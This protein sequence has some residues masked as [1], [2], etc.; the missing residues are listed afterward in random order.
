MC[1]FN[2]DA[3]S[4]PATNAADYAFTPAAPAIANGSSKSLNDKFL[5]LFAPSA[6]WSGL[7][8]WKY[9]HT[10]APG[11]LAGSKSTVI[12]QLG[13]SL[14]K[15]TAQCGI[16]Y[17]YDGE[18]TAAPAGT[19]SNLTGDGT[20]VVGWNAL[21]PGMSAWTY[22]WYV[23][24][25]AG[26]TLVESDVTL[27]PNYIA[28]LADL[29]RVVTHEWGHALGLAHS[30][31]ESAI[32]AGPPYTYY[33]MLA[34]P[35]P[36]DL[37]GCRCLYGM[38]PGM[39]ASYACSLPSQ[40]DFGSVAVGTQSAMQ[41]VTL[42]NSGN[43]PMSV[44]GAAVTTADFRLVSGCGSGTI[45]APGG[46]CT[47]QLAANPGATGPVKAS[48]MLA[49]NDGP[50]EL[51]L[52]VNGLA[53][54]AAVPPN[55]VDVIEFY[56]ASLDHYFISWSAAEIA[57]LDAGNTPTRWTRTGYSFKAFSAAQSGASN[58]CRYY[59]PPIDGSSHF[60]GRNDS[61]CAASLRAHPEFIVEA[62]DYMQ[63][64]LPAVGN[65]PANS[66]P[67]H[68]LFDNRADANHRYTT[69]ANVLSQMMARGWIAEGDGPNL[70]TMCAPQ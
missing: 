13:A 34:A 66:V 61:E 37:R 38:P 18:T 54:P 70:V 1:A 60:F 45:V 68:R 14:G 59:I 36:D 9:N 29:D 20:S 39:Q 12:A 21:D 30:N 28:S 10:N 69:D 40:V 63:L 64:Y 48:L 24:S 15:W 8:H 32:M 55:V 26:R 6:R 4:T 52:A 23:D 43:A 62:Q 27:N 25:G 65:C 58:V 33:N 19:G 7:L 3:Q 11:A 47:M 46:S 57:N 35:Q 42:A 22:D 31:I 16:T 53:S 49:T 51:P 50:Y 56:N 5:F 67:V 41:N 17:Q 44:Q 2:A